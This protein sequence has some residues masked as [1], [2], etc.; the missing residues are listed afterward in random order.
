MVKNRNY[1]ER[2]VDWIVTL[3]ALENKLDSYNRYPKG[4]KKP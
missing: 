2:K 1:L 3:D 4:S